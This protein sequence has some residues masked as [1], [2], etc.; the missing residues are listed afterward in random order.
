MTNEEVLKEQEELF[1]KLNLLDVS[2][3][4]EQKNGLTYLSWAW[5]WQEFKKVCPDAVYEIK[6]FKDETTGYDR[7]YIEDKDLGFMVF[8]SI[9][10]KGITHEM[11]L[12]VMNGANKSMKRESYKYMAGQYEK[13]VESCTM[14]DINKTIMR[15]LVKNIAMFGLGLYIYAGED[16]PEIIKEPCTAEQIAKMRELKV[17]E[18]NV[19]KAYKVKTVEQLSIEQAKEVIDRKESALKG[20]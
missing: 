1:K 10:A 17:I 16:T 12:P 19:C 9:T 14:F 15:C 3:H 8:T 4:T 11:W 18:E 6:K 20:E 2:E 7:P 5:A 13:S